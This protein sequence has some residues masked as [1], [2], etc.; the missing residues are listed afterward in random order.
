MKRASPQ[1]R[2]LFPSG[3][4]TQLDPGQ[5]TNA[6]ARLELLVPE[7]AHSDR[8]DVQAYAL[9][10]VAHYQGNMLQLEQEWEF[11][12]TAL[13]QSWQREAYAI[14]VRLVAGLAHPASRRPNLSEAEHTLRLGVEASRRT[15]DMP[16]LTTFLN[17]LSGLLFA[18]GNYQEGWRLWQAGLELARSAASSPGLWEP[19]SSF[20]YI[21]DAYLADKL[22][23]YPAAHQF[24]ETIYSACEGDDP[25]TLVVALFVRG[26]YARLMND[27]DNAYDD[28]SRCLRLLSLQAPGAAPSPARQLFTLA[29]QAELARAEGHYAR[30]QTYTETA[31]AQVFSDSYTLAALLIDQGLFIYRQGQFADM[32]ATYLR[33]RDVALQMET[34][35]ADEYTH[36]FAQQVARHA[37][38]SSSTTAESLAPMIYTPTPATLTEPL[39]ARE[40]ELLQL[41]AAGRSNQEIARRLVITVGTVK[42]HLEHIYLKLGVHNRTAAIATARTL[43]WLP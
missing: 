32:Q 28:L 3:I 24:Q 36:F 18:R 19:L 14:V 9:A 16:H 4:H 38:A 22:G 11:L 25:D 20:A 23:L 12:S 35:R 26:F 42:K 37:P 7:A 10:Y 6:L 40:R 2:S 13:I 31:L 41:V 29:V 17:R 27:L 39:S 8:H 15:Q 33:L 34:S 30:S 43:A 21:A 5:I 1:S